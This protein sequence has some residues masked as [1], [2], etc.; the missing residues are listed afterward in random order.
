M[1]HTLESPA[2]LSRTEFDA[3]VSEPGDY[4][5][6]DNV[7]SR[8]G[9]QERVEL[10]FMLR[11]LRLPHG[12]RVL[13]VGCGRGVALP[14]LATRLAPDELVGIDLEEAL[15][16]RARTRIARRGVRAALHV[17]DLR[18]LPFQS[19][20]FDLVVDF[21]TSYHVGGGHTGRLTALNEISR[22]LRVGGLFVHET[23]LAQRLAHPVRSLRVRLPFSAVP[24]LAPERS[25]V[26]WAARK[27]IGPV[28]A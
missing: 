19:G 7:E 26:L 16:E 6:F 11:A 9:L 10:P 12:G 4:R 8:N 22:V 1:P 2:R 23:P 13:E 20:Q 3:P 28:L 5:P 18:D 15:V 21:G 24:M 14:V 25:A 17:G 27:R